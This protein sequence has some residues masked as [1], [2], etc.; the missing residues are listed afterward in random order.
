MSARLDELA[1]VV[2]GMGTSGRSA[3]ARPGGWEVSVVSVGDVQDDRVM[4]D[5]LDTLAIDRNV[6]T[7]KHL[8]RPDDLVVT[9]RST[10]IKAALIPPTLARA[11]ADATLLV[12][13]PHELD[14]GPYLWWLLTSAHGRSQLQARAHGSTVLALTPAAIGEM[15][16][17]VPPSH[18][19]LRIAELVE[20]A[21]RAYEAGLQAAR[22]RRSAVRDGVVARYTSALREAQ[23]C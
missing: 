6:K 1:R 20:L 16:V 21:E 2:Q 22:L 14:M 18:E 17:P 13:R 9:A 12:I 8:L 4:L 5:G 15:I 3:G 10:A 23:R 11:V 7:E 19:L